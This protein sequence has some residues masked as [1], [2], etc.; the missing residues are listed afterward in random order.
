M[1]KKKSGIYTGLR[2]VLGLL[3]NLVIVIILI[4]G[5]TYA[6]NFAYKV[7]ADT[8]YRPGVTDTVTVTVLADS[9]SK[10]IIEQVYDSGVIE[11]KYVFMVKTYLEGYY[12]KMKPNTY[13]LSPSMTNSQ[14]LQLLTGQTLEE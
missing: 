5:F 9:S 3:V 4:Q 10:D 2:I 6:F 11:D 12:K 7:F 13:E 14:I 8:P 1:A